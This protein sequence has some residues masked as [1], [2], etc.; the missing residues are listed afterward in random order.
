MPLL[1]YIAGKAAQVTSKD[2]NFIAGEPVEKQ[3]I[4]IN[5][6]RETVSC[7]CSWSFALPQAVS[8][9]KTVS[10]QTG[11][12]GAYSAALRP[13]RRHCRRAAMP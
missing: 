4:V 8:G 5:N 2:H 1:A 10:V 7:E 11:Q 3:L 6:S 9:S 12:S 13:S